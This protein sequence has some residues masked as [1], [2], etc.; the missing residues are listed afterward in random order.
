MITQLQEAM[1]KLKPYRKEIDLLLDQAHECERK[2]Q[3]KLANAIC[4]S[5]CVLK[6]SHFEGFLKRVS[7]AVIT[8]LNKNIPF[9]NLHEEIKRTN[10]RHF[11]KADAGGGYNENKVGINRLLDSFSEF[12]VDLIPEPFLAN[13]SANPKPTAIQNLFSNFGVKEFFAIID[14]NNYLSEP[15]Y[16]TNSQ[17]KH[18]LYKISRRVDSNVSK[19]PYGISKF[20][21]VDRKATKKGRQKTLWEESLNEMNRMRHEVAHGTNFENERA[22]EALRSDYNKLLYLQYGIL[23]F[24]SSWISKKGIAK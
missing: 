12:N 10:S 17:L 8:D 3:Y 11:Y 2:S 20:P 7:N 22:A 5:V 23:E 15:F 14:E 19:F 6:I 1:H 9:S 18:E 13:D 21:P 4:R 24:L 16:V